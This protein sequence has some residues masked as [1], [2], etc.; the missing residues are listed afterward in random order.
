MKF[1]IKLFSRENGIFGLLIKSG[2]I[3]KDHYPATAVIYASDPGQCYTGSMKA[4]SK[5]EVEISG[6]FG[7]HREE[8]VFY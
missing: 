2:D 6:S 4:Y 5:E 3:L 7:I 1:I 8:P